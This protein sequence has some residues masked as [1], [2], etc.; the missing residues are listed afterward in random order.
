MRA[1]DRAWIFLHF[2]PEKIFEIQVTDEIPEDAPQQ[3]VPGWTTFHGII[4]NCPN[5]PTNI[6][7]YQAIPSHPSDF[8]TVYT[9][10]KRA[11]TLFTR[12]WQEMIILTWDKALY[13][14]AQIIKW[15]NADE[16]E[17]YFNQM[18]GLHRATNYMGDI[19][20]IMEGSWFEDCLVEPGIYSNTVISKVN[21]GKAYKRGK[22]AHKLLLEAFLRL[23]WKAFI[24]WIKENNVN[25][26]D[27]DKEQVKSVVTAVQNLM[28]D[29]FNN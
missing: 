18:G 26:D 28:K 7:Y 10:L 11:E 29:A 5:V 1:I 14:K 24:D 22:R 23:K 27:I 9:V 15:R 12:A 16:F 17:N 13:S 19:G 4:S 25:V 2:C 8:N 20:T 6:D 3:D 21:R